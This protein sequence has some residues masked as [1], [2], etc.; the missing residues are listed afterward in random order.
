MNFRPESGFDLA[1]RALHVLGLPIRERSQPPIQSLTINPI[2]PVQ[3]LLPLMQ[4]PPSAGLLPNPEFSFRPT[5]S[6]G[7]EYRPSSS[8]PERV[9]ERPS[10]A[11]MSFTQMLPPRRELPFVVAPKPPTLELGLGSFDTSQQ[12]SQNGNAA[13]V[14]TKMK[15]ARAKPAKKEVLDPQIIGAGPATTKEKQTVEP[16]TKKRKNRT[17]PAK[18]DT[19]PLVEQK[20][21][22][23]STKDVEFSSVTAQP[24]QSSKGTI[25]DCVID[26]HSSS[27]ANQGEGQQNMPD[28][29]AVIKNRNRTPL[30]LHPGAKALATL[31]ESQKNGRQSP[32]T[33]I[34]ARVNNATQ[35]SLSMPDFS[36]E[37]YMG[38]LDEWVR[39][40]QHLP[41]PMPR[42]PPVSD[43]ASYA[44]HSE[45]DR[46]AVLDNMIC[47]CLDDENFAKLV[48]DVDK[49]WKRIGLGF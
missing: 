20:V 42:P 27:P 12:I 48:E 35:T 15:K 39:K 36:P 37:E 47:E 33:A 24:L 29:D 14:Q 19:L 2:Q 11:P 7:Y 21:P 4:Q 30:V 10:T 28:D 17:Q 45:D 5:T 1:Y 26:K 16:Q 32:S 18:K 22:D 34:P 40:Y 8:A 9:S 44:T 13:N 31:T 38:R 23:T 25:P 6:N 41:A 49:S 46:L 3:S 43:L